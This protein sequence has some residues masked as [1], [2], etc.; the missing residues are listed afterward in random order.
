M[1]FGEGWVAVAPHGSMG[2]GRG[3]ERRCGPRFE[4]LGSCSMGDQESCCRMRPSMQLERGAKAVLAWHGSNR[5]SQSNAMCH[6]LPARRQPGAK[7]W[8]Q[9]RKMLSSNVRDADAAAGI[10]SVF[11]STHFVLDHPTSAAGV[12][13]M[14]MGSTVH[15]KVKCRLAKH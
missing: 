15:L 4:N 13:P 8:H 11:Y 2:K 10:R 5:T 14:P 3:K 12:M 7:N 1:L 9:S 6:F